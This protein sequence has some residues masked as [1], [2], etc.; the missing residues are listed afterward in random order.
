MIDEG[1]RPL[2][3]AEEESGESVVEVSIHEFAS[4]YH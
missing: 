3:T 1:N 4:I 2:P